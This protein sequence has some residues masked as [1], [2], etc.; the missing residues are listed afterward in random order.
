MDERWGKVVTQQAPK[1]SNVSHAQ[2]GHSTH[3]MSKK[4]N[5]CNTIN[6]RSTVGGLG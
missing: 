3:I 5:R 6:V 2:G 1:E 4:A